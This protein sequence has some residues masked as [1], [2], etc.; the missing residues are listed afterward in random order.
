MAGFPSISLNRYLKILVNNNYT[1][2][3][4]EQTTDP[5]NPKR[6]ITKIISPGTDIEFLDS[7][8]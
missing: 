2:I 6:E 3:L 5:P 4:V 8:F 7:R 1:T